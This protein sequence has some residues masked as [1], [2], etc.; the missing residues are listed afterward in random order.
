MT[1]QPN[2]LDQ[3]LTDSGFDP[4]NL[5]SG[6]L[7]EAEIAA[8]Q[9]DAASDLLRA[10]VWAAWN[11]GLLTASGA[12]RVFHRDSA[13]SPIYGMPIL[14]ADQATHVVFMKRSMRPGF[15]GVNNA[16]LHD[17]RT[18]LLFGDAKESLTKLVVAVRAS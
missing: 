6:P 16:L 4:E 12:F 1:T 9:R 11:G 8:Q 7:S 3:W 13:G 18:V 2:P 17:P 10:Q 5:S 14:N 15:S